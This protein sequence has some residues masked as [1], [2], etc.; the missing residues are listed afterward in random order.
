MAS[1]GTNAFA[2]CSSLTSITIPSG[3]TYIGLFPFVGC[4]ALEQVVLDCANV[5]CWFS[6]N[7]AIK[8]IV[9]GEDVATIEDGAFEGCTGIERVKMNCVTVAAWFRNNT[10]IKE[11]VIGDNVVELQG[12]AF[13]KCSNLTALTLGSGVTEIRN[14]AFAECSALSSI[15]CH[16]VTPPLFRG[17][18]RSPFRGVDMAIPVYVPAAS[19][20]DYQS[21]DYWKDFTNIIGMETGV[22]H[23]VITVQGSETTSVYD[24]HGHRVENP[25]KGIYIVGGKKT[26]IK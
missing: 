23:E 22:D 3:V 6:G 4:D 9:L 19:V 18:R 13:Y 15:T 16:A 21:A 26:V 8:E 1:I 14:D 10:T 12:N 5:G 17:A 24:L 20:S 7:T 11:V 25:A 2:G